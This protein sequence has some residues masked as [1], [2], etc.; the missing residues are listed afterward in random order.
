MCIVH[1]LFQNMSYLFSFL[2]LSFF[3]LRFIYLLAMVGLVAA[4]WG[5][6]SYG[7]QALGMEASIVTACGLSALWHV[8]SS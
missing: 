3:F 8:G 1:I 4:P 7:A 2:M 6:L 5:I